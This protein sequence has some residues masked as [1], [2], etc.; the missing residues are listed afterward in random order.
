MS[1]EN[2]EVVRRMYEAFHGGDV[3]EALAYFDAD[4]FADQ[5]RRLGGGIS[6]GREELR[7][8]L[9]EWMGTFEAYR[10]E[11][12]EIRGLGNLVFAALTQH[13]RGRG[14]GV[15]VQTRFALLYEV[16]DGKITSLVMYPN[17]GEALGAGGLSD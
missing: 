10:E 5:S 1:E 13:G 15:E 11:I 7:Q 2:V 9:T 6:R 8:S 3:E 17:P 16:C 14:S 12:D 4:V